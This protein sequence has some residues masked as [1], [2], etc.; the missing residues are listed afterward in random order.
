MGLKGNTSFSLH[1][2]TQMNVCRAS[3]HPNPLSCSGCPA[4]GPCLFKAYTELARLYL[5]SWQQRKH[6]SDMLLTLPPRARV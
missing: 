2:H 1:T 5:C 3:A 6:Y 4:A